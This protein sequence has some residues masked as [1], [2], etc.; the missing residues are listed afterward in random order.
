MK[1]GKEFELVIAAIEKGLSPDAI[2]EHDVF[3]PVL[4]SSNGRTRQID[5]SI[6]QGKPPR[7]TLTIV[8]VQDRNS[9][10][11]INTFNGWLCKVE[12]VGAQHLMVVSRKPFPIS[13]KEKAEQSGNKVFLINI[14]ET[15]PDEIPTDFI[16][17]FIDYHN[18][19]LLDDSS[20]GVK[21]GKGMIDKHS[22]KPEV[23]TAAD[24]RFCIDGKNLIDINA[25]FNLALGYEEQSSLKGKM[26]AKL[27]FGNMAEKDVPE[28]NYIIINTDLQVRVSG[29]LIPCAILLN[30]NYR[31][32]HITKKMKLLSYDQGDH[33]NL[34]AW[35][36]D[37]E[38][39]TDKGIYTCRIPIRRD[40]NGSFFL[41]GTF[42]NGPTNCRAEIIAATDRLD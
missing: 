40:N 6:R 14:K 13:I 26:S 27:Y 12:E 23:I 5:V 37:E 9:A 3:L 15:I 11:D 36:F 17:F 42:V 19:T 29:K 28:D 10:V 21:V 33:G 34:G 7:E 31:Y 39:K 22:L 2:V 38:I 32:E 20:L 4:T 30:A 16:N 1:K 35:I 8:E 25:L 24:R 18:F 41:L